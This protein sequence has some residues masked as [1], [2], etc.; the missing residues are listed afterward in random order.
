MLLLKAFVR[1]AATV[2]LLTS[3]QILGFANYAHSQKKIS[4]SD[5]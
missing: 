5:Y 4:K 1:F 2:R 3:Q